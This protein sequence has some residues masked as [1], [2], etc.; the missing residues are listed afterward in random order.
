MADPAKPT[1]ATLAIPRSQEPSPCAL[2]CGT[3]K[4]PTTRRDVSVP[5]VTGLTSA[6][7]SRMA[8]PSARHIL[9]LHALFLVSIAK[10]ATCVAAVRG[11]E[12]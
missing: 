10:I 12:P 4:A 9:A 11:P 2:A 6:G 8:R 7:L 5:T 1:V 3:T